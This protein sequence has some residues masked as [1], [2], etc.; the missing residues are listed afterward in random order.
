MLVSLTHNVASEHPCRSHWLLEAVLQ[1]FKPMNP[2]PSPALERGR[3]GGRGSAWVRSPHLSGELRQT[4]YWACKTHQQQSDMVLKILEGQTKCVIRSLPII[5]FFK[6][7]HNDDIFHETFWDPIG[8][9][10]NQ[11]HIQLKHCE[12]DRRI[13]SAG[14]S[15]NSGCPNSEYSS[16]QKVNNDFVIQS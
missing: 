16:E 4:Q 1:M 9:R 6:G 10:R 14:V 2:H 12:Q 3:G 5:V 11:M 15:R 7:R 13:D 8:A